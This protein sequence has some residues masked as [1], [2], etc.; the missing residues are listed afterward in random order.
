MARLLLVSEAQIR[1]LEEG[2]S[3]GFYNAQHRRTVALR[4]AA[5]LG[6]EGLTEESFRPPDGF[7]RGSVPEAPDH[8]ATSTRLPLRAERSVQRA[9]AGLGASRRGNG[10]DYWLAAGALGGLA[11]WFSVD[12][13][14]HY[15]RDPAD[16]PLLAV[17]QRIDETP[18]PLHLARQADIKGL[19]NASGPEHLGV[20]E[21]AS[22]TS[23]RRDTTEVGPGS[24]SASSE[25][26][27]MRAS[28]PLAS[29]PAQPFPQPFSRS[30]STSSNVSPRDPDAR[31][32]PLQKALEMRSDRVAVGPAEGRYSPLQSSG[33]PASAEVSAA[34]N[35]ATS[36]AAGAASAPA[37]TAPA[38]T[39]TAGAVP[40]G[41]AT[42]GTLAAGAALAGTAAKDRSA[43]EERGVDLCD[44]SDRHAA[45]AVPVSRLKPTPYVHISSGVSQRICIRT[46]DGR[47]E[48]LQLSANE[49]RS[50]FGRAPFTVVSEQPSSIDIFYLGARVRHNGESRV[51]KVIDPDP[52]S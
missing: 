34:G 18:A 26:F 6:I 24:T 19:R 35:A 5:A 52:M 14:Q 40:P 12:A 17:Q 43:S 33:L 4:Y 31:A 21:I 46:A 42:A 51:L 30:T 13:W 38:G 23:T 50:V 9:P 27:E 20:G 10:F 3:R 36:R 48:R 2:G 47:V 11:I 28:P 37:G 25:R 22:G 29:L 7:F 49:S 44:V 39:L 8:G 1:S 41:T 16:D 15:R 32:L 45:T